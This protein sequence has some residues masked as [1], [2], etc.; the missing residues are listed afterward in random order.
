MALATATRQSQ[1][2][3]HGDVVLASASIADDSIQEGHGRRLLRAFRALEGFPALVESRDRLLDLAGDRHV[4]IADIAA[5]VES[6]TAVAIA[7]L[8]RANAERDRRRV[9]TAVDAVERLDP[10]TVRQLAEAV[11]TFDFFERGGLWGQAPRDFRRHALVTQRMADRVAAEIEFEHRERLAL[12]SLL[13]D[14]GKLVLM[15]AYPGYPDRVHMDAKTPEQR[16]RQERKELGVDHALVG[17]VLA[18]RWG[19]PGTIARTIECHHHPDA[20]SEAAIVRLADLLAQYEQGAP[21]GPCE[22]LHAARTVGL[23]QDDL[24]RIMCD[25]SSARVRPRSV[26]PCPLSS[27]ELAALR[28]LARGLVYKQ[29]GQELE[30]SPSTVRSHLHNAYQKLGAIDRAQA[31]LIATKAGWL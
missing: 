10:L 13:H 15:L 27:R 1:G 24:R 8:R 11:R 16:I 19:L 3:D 5:V 20:E 26:D 30:I 12:A 21:V 6:D 28:G 18:R 31:V 22:L 4:R 17:A 2:G 7:V 9:D 14:L 23:G 25:F 29:I